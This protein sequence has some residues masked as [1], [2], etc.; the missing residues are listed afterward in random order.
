MFAI[1]T[2]FERDPMLDLLDRF[3]RGL[4]EFF[5]EPVAFVD[6]TAPVEAAAAAWM[7]AVDIFEEPEVI[8]LIAEVPG[9]KPEDVQITV[10]EN[11]LTIKGTKAQVA[12]EKTEK[13]HRYER[14]YGA[15]ERTFTLPASVVPEQIKATYEHGMLTV[16]LPKVEAAKPHVIKVEVTAPEKKLTA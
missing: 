6:W 7:P 14:A 12:Q 13:V 1:T 16:V 11:V 5:T 15:F 2:R 8:R 4:G 3:D 10:K 9:V